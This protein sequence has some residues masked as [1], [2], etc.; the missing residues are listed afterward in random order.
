MPIQ[1]GKKRLNK[2]SI[3]IDK[4]FISN[5]F[6]QSSKVMNTAQRMN[7]KSSYFSKN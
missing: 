5:N 4:Y 6:S 3:D 7:E 2:N 1:Y